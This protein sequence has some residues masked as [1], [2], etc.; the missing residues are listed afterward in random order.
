MKSKIFT[1]VLLFFY[2]SIINAQFDKLRPNE[3]YF[4]GGFGMTW[5]DDK[6]HYS[7]HLF[8]EVAFANIGIGLDLN[9]EFDASGK[10]RSENFNEFSDYLSII[11]YVR[12]GLKN[13][14][15]Y[16]RLGALDYA[17]LGHGSI[18]YMYNNR[19]SFDARKIGLELDIDF[20]TFGFETVYGSFG[21]SG[22]AGLRGYIRPLLLTTLADVPVIGNLELGASFVSDFNEY[23]GVTS[24]EIDPQTNKFNATN[25]EGSVSVIG[26]DIG[27]PIIRSGIFGFDLYFDYAQIIDYGSGTALGGIFNFSG[28]GL[29]EARAKLE[30]RFNGDDYIPSY[31][32]SFY[33]IERFQF[34]KSTNV[35]TSKI[36]ALQNIGKVG[37]GYYGEL[38]IRIL[39]TFDI[40]GSYQRLDDHPESGIFHATTEIAPE[41]FP[42][43]A[44]AGYDKVNIRDEKDLFTL[45]DRSY[46]F[47]ELGYKPWPYILVSMVYNWTF[48]PIRD[49]DDKIVEYEPQKKIE[50]RISFVYPL[51]F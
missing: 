10:L 24:G 34:N 25:D 18:M 50:P 19:P 28:M 23:A 33:E 44:R 20:T 17:T 6:P 48:T 14:P 7:F 22:V 43:V 27:L 39:G 37:D 26:F 2:V 51:S 36:Q 41:G 12:Y 8:P 5:I 21:E 35:V 42:Y 46:L 45:D 4:G 9:L 3:G 47:A 30:R 1:A 31:F 16:A 32:N 40:L 49:A 29:V 11:R 15:F 38:L 13:D